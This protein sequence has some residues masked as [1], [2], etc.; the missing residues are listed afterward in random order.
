MPAPAQLR[1]AI[2]SV[3]GAMEKV[4]DLALALRPS[5]LDDPGL[6]AAL[7]W[8]ADRFARDVHIETHLAI[9][10]VP[11]GTGASVRRS[12]SPPSA[13]SRRP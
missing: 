11:T 2:G 6:P 5:V 13:S 12:R 10:A 4:R 7:R 1:E 8:Y 9:D 3:D